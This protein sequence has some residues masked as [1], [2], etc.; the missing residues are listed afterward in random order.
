MQAPF[1]GTGW[2]EGYIE[3][4][5]RALLAAIDKKSAA[6]V[7]SLQESLIVIEVLLKTDFS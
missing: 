4:I 6:S 2:L 3:I 7:P 5:H 1:H